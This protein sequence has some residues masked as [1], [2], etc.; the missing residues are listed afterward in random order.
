MLKDI[1]R[2]KVPKAQHFRYSD[3]KMCERFGG[4]VGIP[5]QFIELIRSCV[6]EVTTAVDD[7]ITL[8]ASGT[9]R[10]QG[11]RGFGRPHPQQVRLDGRCWSG[12]LKIR[13]VVMPGVPAL[14][15]DG[16]RRLK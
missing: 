9:A 11:R 6:G 10:W 15:P 8:A 1:E 13:V 5:A 4:I 2:I 14:H 3:P 12:S 16:V 7:R